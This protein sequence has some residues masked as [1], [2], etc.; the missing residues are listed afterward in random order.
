MRPRIE[1]VVPVHNEQLVLAASIRRLHMHARAALSDLD[2]LITIADNAS[3]DQTPALARQLSDELEGVS[4]LRIEHQGRGRALCTAWGASDAELVAYMD[5]DLSTDLEALAPLLAPL[6]RGEADL[7]IGSRLAPGAQVERCLKR[8]LISRAYNRLLR[9][10]LHTRCSDA[11][12]GFKA[13]RREAIVPLLDRIES[14]TW[15]FDTELLYLAERGGVEIF[16]LP[17]R[18]VEDRDSSVRI[19]VTAIENMRGIARLRRAEQHP[20]LSGL[21]D[22][23]NNCSVSSGPFGVIKGRVGQLQDLVDG[24]L[25]VAGNYPGAQTD[26]REL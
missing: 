17:V 1:I 16:E 20:A 13:A 19:V 14:Q 22:R 26:S 12:C 15:F 7:A 21:I 9:L 10:L 23:R 8:E 3:T 11:Q 24:D 5:V 6:L 18:W 25:P 2:V 4:L